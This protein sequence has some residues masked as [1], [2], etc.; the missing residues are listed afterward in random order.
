MELKDFE[1]EVI[2]LEKEI[3]D[4]ERSLRTSFNKN[5]PNNHQ[6]IQ[7]VHI[8]CQELKKKVDELLISANPQKKP[9]ALSLRETALFYTNK[10]EDAI[11]K[12]INLD[13]DILYKLWK[14]T[15]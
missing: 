6:V 1:T 3:W 10:F 11:R 5:N 7:R 8:Q 15:K 9:K 2:K 14:Q 4:F 12:S 13:W